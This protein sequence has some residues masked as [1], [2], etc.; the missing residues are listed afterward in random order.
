MQLV[1]C[2]GLVCNAFCI[3]MLV[4][5]FVTIRSKLIVYL[6]DDSIMSVKLHSNRS[7]DNFRQFV[8][9][10]GAILLCVPY[11]LVNYI[12]HS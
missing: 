6:K 11:P 1:S 8:G 5:Y 10:P 4:L 12:K 3:C 9:L 7:F 2:L